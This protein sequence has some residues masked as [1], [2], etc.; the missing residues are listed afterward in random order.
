VESPFAGLLSG[1]NE[2]SRLFHPVKPEA[3][4][5]GAK[6]G[7]HDFKTIL[8]PLTLSASSHAGF[9][10]ARNLARETKARLVLL[11]VVPFNTTRVEP[12][13]DQARLMKE[14]GQNAESR[15][16]ELA[17]STDQQADIETVVSEGHPAEVIVETARRWEADLIVLSTHGCRGWLK[18]LHRNTALNVT[19]QAPCPVLLLSPGDRPATVNLTIAD[20][21]TSNTY[22]IFLAPQESPKPFRSV[23]QTLFSGL[24]TRP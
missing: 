22:P 14:L 5:W 15:L 10:I 17:G 24:T 3:Y 9:T 23:Y 1:M 6:P 11:H 2:F 21:T 20:R 8:V 12:G 16:S 7:V 18:W 19:R 4:A 13:V